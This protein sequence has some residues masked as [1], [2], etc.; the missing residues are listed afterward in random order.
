MREATVMFEGKEH[1]IRELRHRPNKAWRK[2]LEGHLDAVAT[3]IGQGAKV[4]VSELNSIAHL[5]REVMKFLVNSIDLMGELLV[6]Y[7]PELSDAVESG[8]DSEV[9]DA[10]VE[11]VKLAY[12]FS[13]AIDTLRR[14]GS[15]MPQ[16][17]PNSR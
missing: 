13:S 10:F 8:Y 5:V 11:V 7:S 1:S 6:E 4:D 17:P 15:K 14:L 16:T 2:K 9:V 3:A 12:P